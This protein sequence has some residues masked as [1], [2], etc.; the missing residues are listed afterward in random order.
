[1]KIRTIGFLATL[2][3]SVSVQAQVDSERLARLS[4]DIGDKIEKKLPGWAH[5]S[6]QPI[7]GSK[8]V[9]IQQWDSANIGIKLVITEYD[10]QADAGRA[11]KEF[12]S[13]LK[14]EEDATTGKTSRNSR[15]LRDDLPDLGDGGFTW[16]IRGSEATVFRKQK[17]LVFV[18]IAWPQSDHDEKLSKEFAE[19]VVEVLR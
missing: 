14:I 6:I 1:M 10:D 7:D 18:S 13:Q 16:D 5:R 11:L 4:N 17:L 15:L 3:L 8:N 19:R 12:R 2:L 9:V